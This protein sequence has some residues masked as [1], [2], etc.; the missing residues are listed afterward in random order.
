MPALACAP[1]RERTRERGQML[2][3]VACMMMAMFGITAMVVDV[4]RVFISYH[5]LQAS[6]DAAALA[7]G[8]AMG[9]QNSTSSSTDSAVNLYSSMS[10]DK[11]A[12]S[13]LSGVTTTIA[14]K[15]LTTLTSQGIPCY[16]AG[17]YNAVQVTQTV[18]MPTT[19]AAVFGTPSVALAASSTAAMAG[20][21]TTPYNVA[22]ILD[23]TLSQNSTDD[24]C[25]TN[26]TEMQC[27]LN[28]AQVLLKNLL[29]CAAQVGTCSI[30]NGQSTNAVDRVALFTF[31]AISATTASVDTGCTSPP[32]AAFANQNGYG[33]SSS[34]G[35]YYSMMPQA[36]WTG[37][38]TALAYS[39]PTPGAT[40][41][42]PGTSS[43][44]ATYQVTPFLSDY[45]VSDT[46]TGLNPNSQLYNALG[47]SS[48]C[49][50]I[51]TPNYDGDF[52]TYY[53]GVIYAAQSALIA[54]QA[55]NPGTENV[56]IILSDGNATA[57]H[58]NGNVT[59]MPSP[60][61]SNG[62][63]P[64][65]KNECAQAVTAA[66]YA[67]NPGGTKVYSIAYGSETSGCT[68]DSSGISPCTTM[69][70]MASSPGYFYS[71]YLQSGSGVNTNCVGTGAT[72]TNL[73]QIFYDV[74][75]SL[76]KARLIP[77]STP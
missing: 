73:S 69:Q 57:P 24:N 70:T 27:E 49:G 76:S 17:A 43:T 77:N 22:I 46:A 64:S 67:A 35:G 30:S 2:P 21:A 14:L 15:C 56:M 11:N 75:T 34:F 58:T 32:T 53:A 39:F 19:F 44:S 12:Y 10:S 63:Y 28:G 55:A 52:G 5:Q 9:Q 20:A 62:S 1:A 33:Y 60:A 36:A 54:Q 59:V 16:G 74:Y 38:P 68:S 48:N 72:T 45:R 51:A 37:W 18:N 66:Q 26:V 13:N 40:S 42:A 31:P 8:E 7:G 29:P 61:T 6:T 4:G 23:A 71:D 65:W 50:G 41:Y 25:G 3:L 47:V